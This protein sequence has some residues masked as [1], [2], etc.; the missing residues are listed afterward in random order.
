MQQQQAAY[1]QHYFKDAVSGRGLGGGHTPN[2]P[3]G[4]G[5]GP[6]STSFP[7]PLHYLKQPASVMLASL[8]PVGDDHH[9]SY[10]AMQ[11]LR[12]AHL[13]DVIAAQHH[14]SLKGSNKSPNGLGKRTSQFTFYTKC[15]YITSDN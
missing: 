12:A 10:Q 8:G 11:E 1:A 7:S 4:G 5:G 3:L 2:H 14:N 6:G 15:T 13:P 9:Q